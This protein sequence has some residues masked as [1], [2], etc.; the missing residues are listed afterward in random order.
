MLKF[1]QVYIVFLVVEIV[2]F[3]FKLTGPL[4]KGSASESMLRSLGIFVEC[5]K[6]CCHFLVYFLCSSVLSQISSAER[7]FIF[8]S[9]LIKD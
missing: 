7:L 4:R 5:D 1:F 6:C 2:V 9:F 3:A 8:I